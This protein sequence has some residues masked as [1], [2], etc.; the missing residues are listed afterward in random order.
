MDNIAKRHVRNLSI[1]LLF[2]NR[3]LGVGRNGLPFQRQLFARHLFDRLCRIGRAAIRLAEAR[4]VQARDYAVN[5]V[6]EI[7]A[8][9]KDSGS[10]TL[11][12]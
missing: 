10:L 3:P 1:V 9:R 2:R 8:A 4:P 11:S 7:G 6:L 5:R 12:L